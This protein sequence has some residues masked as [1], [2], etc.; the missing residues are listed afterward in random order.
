[1][2]RKFILLLLTVSTISV[3]SQC[4]NDR[5]REKIFSTVSVTSDILYGSNINKDGDV[6]ELFLDIYQPD[7]DVEDERVLI[8]LIH[9]GSFVGGAKDQEDVI[10]LAEDYAKMGFV[11]ASI[12]Y[13]LGVEIDLFNQGQKFRE[14]VVRGYHDAKAAV[15]FFRKDIEDLGNNYSLDTDNFYMA[16]VSAG[17][18]ITV[19]VAYMDEFEEIPEEIDL[20]L[21]GLTGG[22]DGDSGNPGYSSQVNGVVNICGALVD[23]AWI[24]QDDLPVCS[25][26]GTEDAVVPYGTETIYA[27]GFVNVGEV[28]GSESITERAVEKGLTHCFEIHEGE[29]HVPHVDNEAIYDT[30]LSISSNFLSHLICPTTIDLDCEYRE[31]EIVSVDELSSG[32][33]EFKIWPNPTNEKLYFSSKNGG[34]VL[35]SVHNMIGREVKSINYPQGKLDSFSVSDLAAGTYIV[36]IASQGIQ[37]KYKI[38]IQ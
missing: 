19:H 2:L 11:V 30:T 20:T 23:T 27:L 26:H 1:M 16:G 6:E 38:I 25:F 31:L 32:L 4:E 8:V 35:I 18:I 3:F 10:Y 24:Q 37:E 15:R 29:G 33:R 21:E 17:G 9:G 12:E 7:N 5:Y 28:D 36:T 14:A 13:R 34:Q 22:L